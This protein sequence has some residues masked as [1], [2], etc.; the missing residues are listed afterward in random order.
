MKKIVF[1]FFALLLPV[2]IF[3][4]LRSF[5]KNE[6]DVPVLFADSVSVPAACSAYHYTRPYTLADSAL[7]SVGWKAGDSLTIIVFADTIPGRRQEQE[8]QLN[9]VKTEFKNH[10][11]AIRYVSS[12]HGGKDGEDVFR[13]SEAERVT[14]KSCVFLMNVTDDAVIV[15]S[16]KQIRGQYNLQKR[17][18]ADRMI[19]QEM[20]ILFK[21]Y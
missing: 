16:K 21:R 6:F 4:F 20:N 18:D 15:D 17:E 19:M 9:R 3:I 2:L 14:L 13:F 5:G 8:I 10:A 1:L 7:Q 12:M 11:Y